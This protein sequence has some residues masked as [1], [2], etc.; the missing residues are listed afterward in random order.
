MSSSKPNPSLHHR[1][2]PREE[3]QGFASWKPGAFGGGAATAN[4]ADAPDQQ[5]LLHAA[6]HTGYQEG[7]RDGLAALENFKRSVLQQN[8]AQFGALLQ[9][10]DEQLDTL[11]FDMART[12]TRVA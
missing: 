11:E 2:I 9:Q 10:F 1:F 12:L 5:A 7:Y 8:A 3:L 4:A 6:R